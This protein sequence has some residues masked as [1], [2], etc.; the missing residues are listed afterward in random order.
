MGFGDF[1]EEYEKQCMAQKYDLII[2]QP[3]IGA[4]LGNIKR[5]LMIV[6]AVAD[7]TKKVINDEK[8]TNT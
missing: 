4:L 7:Y 3:Q 8:N 1:H 5:N 6:N 2:E